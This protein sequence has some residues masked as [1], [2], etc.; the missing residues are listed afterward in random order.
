MTDLAIQL[1]ASVIVAFALD[2]AFVFKMQLTAQTIH[3]GST[4]ALRYSLGPTTKIIAIIAYLIP[5][6]IILYPREEVLDVWFILFGFALLFY[7]YTVY[8]IAMTSTISDGS[9]Q[10]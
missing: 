3:R 2:W 7:A 9:A 6:N 8:R 10:K 5:A 1:A 4:E